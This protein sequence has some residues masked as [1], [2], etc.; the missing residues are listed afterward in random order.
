MKKMEKLEAEVVTVDDFNSLVE[1]V[2]EIVDEVENLGGDVS[3]ETAEELANTKE[4]LSR[5]EAELESTK[6]DLKLA[7]ET[8]NSE[9][10]NPEKKGG[11][12]ASG[13]KFDPKAAMAEFGL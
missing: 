9:F 11:K 10:E 6:A 1:I 8:S 4:K 13:A 5:L 7:K 2:N 12:Q 3:Q